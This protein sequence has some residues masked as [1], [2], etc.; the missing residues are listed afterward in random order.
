MFESGGEK[1]QS[2]YLKFDKKDLI[3]KTLI[4]G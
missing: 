4:R 3:P 2:N 1:T